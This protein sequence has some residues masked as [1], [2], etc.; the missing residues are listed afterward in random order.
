M[1]KAMMNL[2]SRSKNTW[3]PAKGVDTTTSRYWLNWRLLLCC[4][5]ILTSMGMAVYLIKRYEGPNKQR[6]TNVEEGRDDDDSRTVVYVDDSW[7]PCM[8]Q[9]HPL[10]LMAFRVFA[11]F[12]LILIL[13]L[14][15]IRIGGQIFLYYT[16]ILLG[17]Q[18]F[19]PWSINLSSDTEISLV[20]VLGVSCV[21][22]GSLL[23]V[24]GC[25]H[26]HIGLEDQRHPRR[27]AG[28]WG[29][30][31]QITF[32]IMAGAVVLTDCIFWFIIVPFLSIKY[33]FD[34]DHVTIALCS[35]CFKDMSFVLRNLLVCGVQ[36]TVALHSTNALFLLG[37]AA[38][39]SLVSCFGLFN[40]KTH[41]MIISCN[42]NYDSKTFRF[43]AIPMVSSS[44]LPSLDMFF[45]RFPMDH[46]CVHLSLVLTGGT[47]THT[48]LWSFLFGVDPSV[49]VRKEADWMKRDDTDDRLIVVR[50]DRG[51]DFAYLGCYQ[52]TCRNLSTSVLREMIQIPKSSCMACSME[53][54]QTEIPY[55]FYV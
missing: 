49:S 48:M 50:A 28:F 47:V 1:E 9:I 24:Y 51:H 46:S 38:L 45:C 20:V 14:N 41:P 31:F 55:S 39:N 11:F 52:P 40:P 5:W 35:I 15:V 53:E 32:Q 12:V 23:S 19:I 8:K 54:V 33:N 29:Y 21:Q 30:S 34:L 18:F 16:K 26:N 36:L 6:L 17:L 25:Y 4:A 2:F 3:H 27:V 10:W 13:T 22:F 7:K 42:F 43:S 44:I 37:D